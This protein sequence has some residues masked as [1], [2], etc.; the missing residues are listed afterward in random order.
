MRNV[1]AICLDLDDTLWDLGPV[2]TRAELE[3][4]AWLDCRYPRITARF[5]IDDIRELR[6]AVEADFPGQEFDLPL[7]R[8]ATFARLAREAGY[9][10]AL[11]EEAFALFQRLRNEVIP[12]PDVHAGLER[13]ARRAPLLA[14]TNGTADLASIGLRRYFTAVVS[15]VEVGAAKP[16]ARVFIAACERVALQPAQIA[17]AGDHPLNDVDAARAVG[18]PA[19]WVNRGLHEWPADL[20]PAEHAVADLHELAELLG[21]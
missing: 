13:L 18:M 10:E 16:D 12:Y 4:Y 8:R 20:A 7:L 21:A 9:A 1:K 6:R 11:A 17:H 5:S 19:V 15:A 14:L 2:L 3:L